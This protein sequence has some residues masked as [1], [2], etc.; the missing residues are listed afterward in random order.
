VTFF[1][2]CYL[3]RGQARARQRYLSRPWPS[4]PWGMQSYKE[5][6]AQ[7]SEWPPAR[8]AGSCCRSSWPKPISG[9]AEFS[10]RLRPTSG[11]AEFSPEGE[12]M[13]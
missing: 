6:V 11:K 2:R 9:E 4:L 1:E 10:S 12:T 7:L 5:E 13:P 8:F 3:G